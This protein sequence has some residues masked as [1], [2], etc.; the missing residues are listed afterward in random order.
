[1]S[2]FAVGSVKPVSAVALLVAIASSDAPVRKSV[3]RQPKLAVAIQSFVRCG[4]PLPLCRQKQDFQL[5]SIA[6]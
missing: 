5:C 4:P 6:V 3:R 1:V 2:A